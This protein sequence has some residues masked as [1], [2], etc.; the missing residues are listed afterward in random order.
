MLGDGLEEGITLG[1]NDFDGLFDM[2]GVL[3]G[4]YETDSD[5]LKLQIIRSR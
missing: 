2:D 5:T 4:K 1:E 3:L